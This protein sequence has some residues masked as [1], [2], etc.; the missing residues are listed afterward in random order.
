NQD[1][2]CVG[3]WAAAGTLAQPWTLELPARNA[4]VCAVADG[5][6]G[7]AAGDIASAVAI[8]YVMKNAARMTGRDGIAAVLTEVHEALAAAMVRD[9]S[10]EGMGTTIA[11]LACGPGAA[12]VFNVGDSRVYR[13]A[14]GE[15]AQLSV[16]D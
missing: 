7:H 2:L 10:T 6:G 1:H 12:A 8:S 9:P 16:D 11:G 5:L 4:F 14:G 3:P 13:I 15:A